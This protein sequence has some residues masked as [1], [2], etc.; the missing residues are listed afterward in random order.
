M[1][2]QDFAAVFP[3]HIWVNPDSFMLFHTHHAI[4]PDMI[5][6]VKIN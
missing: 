2:I 4:L 1:E 5:S 3:E 6:T